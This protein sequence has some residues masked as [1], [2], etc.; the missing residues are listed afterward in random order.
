MYA[1]ARA[2]LARNARTPQRRQ[3]RD[4]AVAILA[5]ALG[6]LAWRPL[7]LVLAAWA[8][9]VVAACAVGAPRLRRLLYRRD[10]HDRCITAHYRSTRNLAGTALA[11]CIVTPHVILAQALAGPGRRSRPE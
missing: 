5:V 7:L 6:A 3:L 1:L 4:G 9:A 10:H 8:V 11:A 2:I